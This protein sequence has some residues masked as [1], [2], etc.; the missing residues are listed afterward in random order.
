MIPLFVVVTW[1]IRVSLQ[2]NIVVDSFGRPLIADF[3]VSQIVEDI[4]G[5]PFTQSHGVSES[6]RWFAPE[7][8]V[9][10]GVLSTSADIYAFSMTV[11]EVCSGLPLYLVLLN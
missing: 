7:L 2:S 11:L 6:Y 8:C 5:V 3:G 1:L 4:T 10:Q 9:G